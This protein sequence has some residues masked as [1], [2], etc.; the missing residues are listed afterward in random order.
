MPTRQTSSITTPAS[1]PARRTPCTRPRRTARPIT[2]AGAYQ[3]VAAAG[4]ASAGFDLTNLP[5]PAVKLSAGASCSTFSDGSASTL[6]EITYSVK[7]GKVST[8]SVGT[9]S[10]WIAVTA[11][12]GT[13][14]FSV[15]QSI[16]TGNFARLFAIAPASTVYRSSCGGGVKSTFT[17]TTTAATS[18]TVTV[19]FTAPAAGTYFVNVKLTAGELK[20]EAAPTPGTVHF[21]FSTAGMVGSARAL[22]LTTP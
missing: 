10:Y 15:E 16:T 5:P 18:G 12:A 1:S 20:G 22:D 14:T 11:V 13:N 21:V 6:S 4:A 3:L 17:Q 9:F 7:K 19:T 8:L 2:T